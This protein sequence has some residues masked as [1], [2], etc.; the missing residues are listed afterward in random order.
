[1]KITKVILLLLLMVSIMGTEVHTMAIKSDKVPAWLK[2]NVSPAAGGGKN[3]NQ[4]ASAGSKTYG[5]DNNSVATS[6]GKSNKP[7]NVFVDQNDKQPKNNDQIMSAPAEVP[8]WLQAVIGAA[9]GAAINNP[10]VASAAMGGYGTNISNQNP[11]GF[12]TLRGNSHPMNGLQRKGIQLH[13]GQAPENTMS[14]Y[15]RSLYADPSYAQQYSPYSGAPRGYGGGF[16]SR[17]NGNWGGGGG[18][19]GDWGG[20]GGYSDTPAWLANMYLNSW[21]IR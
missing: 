1:M 9:T 19:G 17:Y 7:S 6:G 18:G 21:N 20:G 3:N 14:D 13:S 16:G 8:A 10:V 12:D 15:L 4:L 2:G 5:K 11:K